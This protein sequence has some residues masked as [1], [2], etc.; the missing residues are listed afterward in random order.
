MGGK[1]WASVL[2]CR[3]LPI[4]FPASSRPLASGT[5]IGKRPPCAGGT[6]LSQVLQESDRIPCCVLRRKAIGSE[7][8]PVSCHEIQ[9]TFPRYSEVP[10][11]SSHDGTAMEDQMSISASSRPSSSYGAPVGPFGLFLPHLDA[12]LPSTDLI[13]GSRSTSCGRSWPQVI[14]QPQDFL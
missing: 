7:R 1:S 9:P 8:A 5:P 10:C 3:L 12:P 2:W 11:D 4:S 14:S 6:T 13:P